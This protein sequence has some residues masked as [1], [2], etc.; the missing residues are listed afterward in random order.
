MCQTCGFITIATGDEQYYK[1][2]V[3]LLRSYRRFT[4][5]RLPFA[6]LAD[7]E[8]EYTDQ[9]DVVRLFPHATCSYLDKLAMGELLP[10]DTNI[11]IDADCLAYGDLNGLF[12]RFSHADDFS[13]FGRVLPL[14]DTTGWFKYENLGD[15]KTSVDYVVGL[16]G[17]IYFIRR[18]DAAKRVF[19]TAKALAA[20]YAKYQFK[21]RFSTPGD[22][23]L[24]ALSMA[25]HHCH[26]I[27]HA[28]DA[29]TCYWEYEHDMLLD[30]WNGRARI[31]SLSVPVSLVHW[32]TRFTLQPLYQR[33]V[34]LMELRLF[35]AG[36][37]KA[38]LCRA[39]YAGKTIRINTGSLLRRAKNKAKRL[40]HESF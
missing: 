12:E 8:N 25:I 1:I 7:R 9:F 19:E 32:G 28:L 24:I 40:L 26:P 22:E 17:G 37:M 6:V 35:D 39:A 36:S 10:F 31:E 34:K 21:G 4:D 23:P 5:K 18:T 13:C 2:A 29:I 20:D 27:P 33:E 15:L 3:N 30:Q 11:F 16:H 14:D 38:A